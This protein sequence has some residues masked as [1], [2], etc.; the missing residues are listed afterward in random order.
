M[1]NKEKTIHDLC[2][3]QWDANKHLGFETAADCFCHHSAENYGG[4]RD[5][6]NQGFALQFI[7]DAVAEKI[8]REKEFIKKGGLQSALDEMRS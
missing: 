4:R 5:Y 3:L 1:I 8:E 2:V 7:K 6:E